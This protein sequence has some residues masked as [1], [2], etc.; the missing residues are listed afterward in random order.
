MSED[1]DFIA[2]RSSND[3]RLAFLLDCFPDQE[4]IFPVLS[5]AAKLG[6]DY[7]TALEWAIALL[8]ATADD[9]K[10]DHEQDGDSQSSDTDK[11]LLLARLANLFPD[12]NIEDLQKALPGLSGESSDEELCQIILARFTNKTIKWHPLNVYFDYYEK[13]TTPLK[14]QSNLLNQL[15]IY[16]SLTDDFD[17]SVE[18]CRQRIQ[19]IREDR[20]RL[21]QQASHAY[22][23][24]GSTL[25]AAS[26]YADQARSLSDLLEV[27]TARASY[28]AFL[29][30]NQPWL[31]GIK[32]AAA[33]VAYAKEITVDLHEQPCKYALGLLKGL[34]K[35][36]HLLE[37]FGR[38]HIV[39]GAGIHSQMGR[40]KLRPA[41]H[42][43]LQS[44]EELD[45]SF[46][47]HAVFTVKIKRRQ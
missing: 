3:D 12:W 8:E 15:E 7:E 9:D 42:A 23:R 20:Q 41:I 14:I 33:A 31:D 47:G 4:R 40:A 13:S 16:S 27:W 19:E 21:Y 29:E 34:L 46:D 36:W 37:R 44:L 1:E 5:R 35:E 10:D 17:Y 24:R 18:E 43:Y 32:S 38:I 2:D 45:F 30:R 25:T 11:D 22:E 39:T 28:L 26:Y 6:S